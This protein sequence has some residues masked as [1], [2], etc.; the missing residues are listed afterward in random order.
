MQSVIG[1]G[2][3]H[4][5]KPCSGDRIFCGGGC[6][7]HLGRDVGYMGVTS[8]KSRKLSW[9][10]LYMPVT[11]AL[12]EQRQAELCE[13]VSVLHRTLQADTVKPCLKEK[14]KNLALSHLASRLQLGCP[15]AQK[16]SQGVNS[17]KSS[18]WTSEN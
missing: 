16:Q 10:W 15:A 11:S 7:W 12:R 1:E 2:G 13:F 9:V 4:T 6:V 5:K 14:K 8:V 17:F 18:Q 3:R